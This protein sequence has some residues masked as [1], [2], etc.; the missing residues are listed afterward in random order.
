MKCLGINLTEEVQVLHTENYKILFKEIKEELNKWKDSSYSLN[1]TLKMERCGF[2]LW[3][4]KIPWGKTQQPTPVF[5]PGKSH[6]QRSP[7]DYI[8][9]GVTRVG[10]NL[11]TWTAAYQAPLSMGFSRQEDWSGLPLPSPSN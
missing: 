11:V 7:V 6:G 8:V 2:D 4:R 9:H 1:R 5:L 10:H 3:V